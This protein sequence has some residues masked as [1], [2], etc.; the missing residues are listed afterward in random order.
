M[1]AQPKPELA[2]VIFHPAVLQQIRDWSGASFLELT[3]KE[4]KFYVDHGL[5]FVAQG[6]VLDGKTRKPTG[7]PLYCLTK[8]ALALAY[9]DGVMIPRYKC[10]VCAKVTAGRFG[11]SVPVWYP[12]KHR[13][14]GDV[15]DGSYIEAEVVHE[16]RRFD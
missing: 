10:T 7:K 8:E 9:P 6:E 2:A 5:M 12:R 13:I 15:C 14:D 4:A 1:S 11:T 3:R 16:L